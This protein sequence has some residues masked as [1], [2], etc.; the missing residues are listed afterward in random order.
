MRCKFSYLMPNNDV[1]KVV[2]FVGL[3][4]DLVRHLAADEEA[5]E[6]H[7]DSAHT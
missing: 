2:E 4:G 5:V 3:G 7:D 1:V 6:E